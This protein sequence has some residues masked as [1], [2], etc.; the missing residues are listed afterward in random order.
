MMEFV[1]IPFADGEQS[2]DG[3][4]CYG[5]VRL[6]YREQL[7]IEIPDLRVH[8]DHSN[9]VWATYLKEISE[10]WHNVDEPEKYD[11]IAMAQDV[12]HPRIVNHV[13]VY[14]GD[15]K[16]LHTLNK[17]DSH[18][19]SLESIKYMIRGYHRWQH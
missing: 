15:G 3:A 13:G 9:R 2:F 16:V 18:V 7:G 17:V 10:H 8:S 1:G 19:V 14:L 6:F 11:V 12:N 5:L 4:N